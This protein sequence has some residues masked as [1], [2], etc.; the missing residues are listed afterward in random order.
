MQE[1]GLFVPGSCCLKSFSAARPQI[2]WPNC[3]L[4]PNSSGAEKSINLDTVAAAEFQI[5]SLDTRLHPDL[6]SYLRNLGAVV[7]NDQA[8]SSNVVRFDDRARF[9]SSSTRPKDNPNKRMKKIS[10]T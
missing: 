8:A 1:S 2:L 10:A 4:R 7:T 6:L 3:D 5:W 9:S